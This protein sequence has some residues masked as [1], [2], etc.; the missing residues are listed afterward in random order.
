MANM[1]DQPVQN[2]LEKEK[3]LSVDKKA[4]RMAFVLERA[5]RDEMTELNAAKEEGKREGKAEQLLLLLELKFK[6]LPDWVTPKLDE[7][8]EEQLTQWSMSFVMADTLEQVFGA[9]LESSR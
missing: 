2:T 5:L 3:E 9:G 8:S 7:A 1:A 6:A 4:R